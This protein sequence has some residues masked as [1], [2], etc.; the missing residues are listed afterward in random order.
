MKRY[1]VYLW[2]SLI[3]LVAGGFVFV[4]LA[5]RRFLSVELRCRDEMARDRN[6]QERNRFG[7]VF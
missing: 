1:T 3:W 6:K 5:Q 4:L 2:L 7:Q